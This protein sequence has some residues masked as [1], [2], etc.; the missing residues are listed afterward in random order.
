MIVLLA[1]TGVLGV[2]AGASSVPP[3]T[4]T[5]VP[6]VPGLDPVAWP[7][8]ESV[9]SA[10]DAGSEARAHVHD[11]I[12]LL[13]LCAL[14]AAGVLLVTSRGA[15]LHRLRRRV[16]ATAW[17]SRAMRVFAPVTLTDPLSWGVCRR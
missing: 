2:C 4:T 12:S 7:G 14:V 15:P 10:H 11:A 5:A 16:Q 3:A 6:A 9:I 17:P 1:L 13:C 8:G